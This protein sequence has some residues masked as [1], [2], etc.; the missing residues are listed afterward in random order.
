MDNVVLLKNID[1]KIKKGQF[2]CIVGKVGSG[3]SSLLSAMIGDMLPVPEHICK[4]FM[5]G[6][7]FEK[8]LSQEEAQGF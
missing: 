8:E 6:E 3:K 1:I 5:K 7:G 2:V 4:S